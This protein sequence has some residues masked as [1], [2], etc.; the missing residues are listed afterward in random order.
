MI[1]LITVWYPGHK[2]KE[3]AEKFLKQAEKGNP[4][5]VKKW[6]SFATSDGKNSMK[7]YHLVYIEKGHIDEGLENIHKLIAPYYKIEGYRTRIEILSSVTEAAKM[8]PLM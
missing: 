2:A 6:L 3:V 8:L 7:G 4:K 5:Y 1:I